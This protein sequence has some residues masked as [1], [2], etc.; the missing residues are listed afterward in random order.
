MRQVI[1]DKN[2]SKVAQELVL[3]LLKDLFGRVEK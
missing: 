3:L 1:N 2:W